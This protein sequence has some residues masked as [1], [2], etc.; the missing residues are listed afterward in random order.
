MESEKKIR[1][2]YIDI[3]KAIAMIGVV[4]V[5]AC[6]NNKEIWLSTNA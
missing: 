3:V 5:H 1:I 4:M 2:T 6:V